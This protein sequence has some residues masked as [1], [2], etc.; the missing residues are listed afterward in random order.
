[1]SSSSLHIV[2]FDVPFP[3][4]YGGVIDVYYKV[5]ALSDL[6]VQIHLHCYQ[7]GRDQSKLL[8]ELCTSVHYYKRNTRPS[9]LI[10]RKPYIV[11]TRSN[12]DLIERLLQDDFPILFEGLHTAAII[13]DKRFS[14]RYKLLRTHNVE[15]DYYRGL[16]QRTASL[17]KRMYYAWEAKK[18]KRFEKVVSSADC[19][20]AI[21]ESDQ[22][23]FKSYKDEVQ[24]LYP[25]HPEPEPIYKEHSEPFYENWGYNFC[26]Y[27]GNLE[28]EENIEAAEF[29]VE[30]VSSK[31]D[32]QMVIAGKGASKI[33][34]RYPDSYV[35]FVDEPDD[36]MMLKMVRNAAIHLLPTFQSTGFKLKLL[37]ALSAGRHVM[38]SHQMTEGTNLGSFCHWA[39]R[40]EDW[41]EQI[42]RLKMAPFEKSVFDQ[43]QKF[44]QENYSNKKKAQA[45]LDLI[46]R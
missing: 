16:A 34:L 25:F 35:L 18:L 22:A 37:L 26:L 42:S 41:V 39:E 21:S 13:D 36:E 2:S 45:I 17:P 46:Q 38:V 28:V 8:A 10:S 14:N 40:W 7:Y 1:M 9:N 4:D 19:V 3:A 27:Q 23:H 11:K 24:L 6:G 12:N 5:K 43:R 44:L 30:K 15:H 20:L 33:G 32:T 29:L 31:I